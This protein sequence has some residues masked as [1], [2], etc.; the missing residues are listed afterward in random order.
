MT[1]A[2]QD[3]LAQEEIANYMRVTKRTQYRLVQKCALPAF[4][5]GGTWRFPRDEQRGE[6]P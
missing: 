3:I 6:H 5:L 1:K 2:G 4:T